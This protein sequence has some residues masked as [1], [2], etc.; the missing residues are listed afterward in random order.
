M[1]PKTPFY[2]AKSKL[3]LDTPQTQNHFHYVYSGTIQ[4]IIS[5]RIYTITRMNCIKEMKH[6]LIATFK[7]CDHL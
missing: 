4:H 3:K 6:I 7:H 1:W 2:Q 5:V